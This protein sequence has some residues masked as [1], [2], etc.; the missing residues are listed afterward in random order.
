MGKLNDGC[1][2]SCCQIYFGSGIADMRIG[3]ERERKERERERRLVFLD[4]VLWPASTCAV[5]SSVW[6]LIDK[7]I[8]YLAGSSNGFD[9]QAMAP[10]R[11]PAAD[12]GL[13][14]NCS[15]SFWCRNRDRAA[16]ARSVFP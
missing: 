8:S 7:L 6:I 3:R 11:S 5:A 2:V 13:S 15:Q 12:P 10:A 1:W 16:A 14:R 9:Q 4:E